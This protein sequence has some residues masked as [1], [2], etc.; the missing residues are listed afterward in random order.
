MKK[1]DLSK[2]L[3]TDHLEDLKKSGLSDDTIS[4]A[5]IVSISADQLIKRLG[6][7]LPSLISSY[8]IPYNENFSRFRI[9]YSNSSNGKKPKYLQGKNTGNRLYI[10]SNVK[11][12]LNNP[13]IPLYITEGE[14]KAL[15]ATQEG[16]YCIGLSGLW[17]WSNGNK[18]LI[19]DFDLIALRDRAIYIVP[20][21]DYKTPNKNGYKKNLKKAVNELAEKLKAKGAIVS[22]VE[23][24]EGELK[25]LDD[26]LCNHTIEEFKQLPVIEFKSLQERI[27]EA[28]QD[29]YQP[30][31]NEISG[32]KDELKKELLIKALS[33]KL[34]INYYIIKRT[35]KSYQKENIIITPESNIIIAHPSYEIHQDFISLGFRETI[36]IDDKPQDRNFY[37][38][39]TP[40]GIKIC[41]NPIFQLGN[42]KIIFDEKNRL[43]IKHTDKWRKT[44]ILEF[45][46]NPE[47]PIGIY[48]ELKNLLKQYIELPKDEGYGLLSAWIIATYFYQI[49]YAFPFLFLYG[50]KQS[51]KSRLLT[52]LERLCF[53]AM[54][55]KGVSVASMSDSI[56]GVRG[57]FLND[58]AEILLDKRN[59]EIVGI[60]A[61]SYTK[62]GG[63][64]RVVSLTN[65]TRSMV[66]FE[67]YAPKAFAS[68]KDIDSDLK[69]RC[70]LMPMIRAKRDYPEPEAF[71]SVW[72]ETRDKLY[73][74]LFTRWNEVKKIYPNTGQQVNHRIKELWKP[75]ET[76]LRLEK[77]SDEDMRLIFTYF[78]QSMNETQVELSDW[79]NALFEALFKLLKDT[80]D[81]RGIYSPS[82]IANKMDVDDNID[83]KSL[84][85]WVGKALRQL[86]LYDRQEGRKNKK[87][88]YSFSIDHIKD[89][90]Y[91]YSQSN[92]FDGSMVNSQENQAFIDDHCRNLNGNNGQFNGNNTIETIAENLMVSEKPLLYKGNYQD[93]KKT[94]KN[95]NN[96][97]ENIID[98]IFES[99]YKEKLNDLEQIGWDVD[100][101]KLKKDNPQL[102][103]DIDQAEDR[104]NEVWKAGRNGGATIEE[105]KN[106]L[107]EWYSLMLE[108]K[109]E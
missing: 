39:A 78:I 74:L 63:N 11:P 64:R 23:L 62:G 56:D 77:V 85:K 33:K 58:Q 22:I 106:A 31:L 2:L 17:N 37:I 81:G 99:L 54:K 20:D 49:F 108:A 42:K 67:T 26:Y 25:G 5:G 19:P 40:N 36:I 27:A 97:E 109:N 50:K 90:L 46:D 9:F 15:K 91:R 38:I 72:E 88:A 10:P 35:I 92:G 57:T 60:L 80:N 53:N 65:K 6:F 86:N 14:K 44:N 48:Q 87:R 105:F 34:K 95:T 41:N 24:P 89:V 45:I 55:I 7:T 59:G 104:L 76:I 4:K 73:R 68:T 12:I 83:K 93:T 82:E 66:E 79:E 28:R 13:S 3:N 32:I 61:D 98:K 51:G 30:L 21:N 69:D 29:N 1:E 52:V 107:Y 70:I 94:I 18:E 43:L 71:L 103:Y 8:E 101:N 47:A 102:S 16:L 100:L 96:T 84:T 75:L